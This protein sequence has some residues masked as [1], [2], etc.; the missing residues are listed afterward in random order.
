MNKIKIITR[1]LQLQLLERPA[2]NLPH[3]LLLRDVPDRGPQLP[4]DQQFQEQDIPQAAQ[5]TI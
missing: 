5:V 2:D 1:C 3:P 4:P